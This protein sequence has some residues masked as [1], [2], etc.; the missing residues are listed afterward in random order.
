VEQDASPLWS[1]M[2]VRPDQYPFLIVRKPDAKMPCNFRECRVCRNVMVQWLVWLKANVQEYAC[3]EIDYE[4]LSEIPMNEDITSIIPTI[5][6]GS[7]ESKAT[8]D[9]ADDDDGTTP[10]QEMGPMQGGAT[11]MPRGELFNEEEYLAQP[12]K[13]NSIEKI[14]IIETLRKEFNIN[15]QD[16]KP[17]TPIAAWP[18]QGAF[19]SDYLTPSLQVMTFPTLFPYG[20]GDVTKKDRSVTVTMTQSNQHLLNYTVYDETEKRLVYPFA[21]HPR[22]L[23]WAQNTCERHRL[24]GQKDVYLSKNPEEGNLSEAELRRILEC[25]GE[26]LNSMLGRMQ[27]YNGNINGSNAYFSSKKECQ[28]GSHYWLPTIIGRIFTNC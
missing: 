8:N 24:N 14:D 2:L 4:A 21:S 18:A 15:F 17:L 6:E 12:L 19:V 26:E 5:F 9:S 10:E 16:T 27:A 11:G 23:K 20:I 3:I 28:C 1:K 13:K 22:W 25:G 7:P